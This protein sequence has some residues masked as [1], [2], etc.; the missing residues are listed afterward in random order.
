MVFWHRKV[1]RRFVKSMVCDWDWDIGS[2]GG[3]EGEKMLG[4]VSLSWQMRFHSMAEAGSWKLK[5]T[6]ASSN[7]KDYY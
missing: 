3:E 4:E 2:R 5:P 1:V 7:F 6:M